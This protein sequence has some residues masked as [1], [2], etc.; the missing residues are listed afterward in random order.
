MKILYF[1]WC[2]LCSGVVGVIWLAEYF[3]P[4]SSLLCKQLCA[5]SWWNPLICRVLFFSSSFVTHRV[6]CPRYDLLDVDLCVDNLS[7]ALCKTTRHGMLLWQTSA[8]E[9]F[10]EWRLCFSEE[11]IFLSGCSPRAC[12]FSERRAGGS[13]EAQF[14]STSFRCYLLATLIGGLKHVFSYFALRRYAQA[15]FQPFCF[16]FG[17]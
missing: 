7:S 8:S 17:C 16:L 12:C 10:F 13:F 14:R 3:V 6:L 9:C 5:L 11:K 15:S 1:R 2:I 4:F